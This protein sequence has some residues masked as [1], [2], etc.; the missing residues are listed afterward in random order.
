MSRR[1][2]D[3]PGSKLSHRQSRRRPRTT[4]ERLLRVARIDALPSDQRAL[5]VRETLGQLRNRPLLLQRRLGKPFYEDVLAHEFSLKSIHQILHLLLHLEFFE[6][7]PE[8]LL[9]VVGERLLSKREIMIQL[10]RQRTETIVQPHDAPSIRVAKRNALAAL[11]RAVQFDILLRRQHSTGERETLKYAAKRSIFFVL[12][13]ELHV[14]NTATTENVIVLGYEHDLSDLSL[15]VRKELKDTASN[16][17]ELPRRVTGRPAQ[18]AQIDALPAE[19]EF[20]G[21]QHRRVD[22]NET[23][24][25]HED[26]HVL[27]RKQ[28]EGQISSERVE[29]C[30]DCV[31]TVHFCHGIARIPVLRFRI[32]VTL[33][34][35]VV[36]FAQVTVAYRLHTTHEHERSGRELN[37]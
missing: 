17:P 1:R 4:R 8:C 20:N 37:T 16:A 12:F 21:S 29:S 22:V 28:M 34:K 32:P 14:R 3:D 33:S 10:Q 9:I 2:N 23:G 27:H 24:V 5:S 26:A 15:F 30:H 19:R 13:L 31:L 36:A 35:F 18:R 6:R 7:S 11:A 25:V